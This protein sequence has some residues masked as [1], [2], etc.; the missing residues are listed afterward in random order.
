MYKDPS[1]K[2][3]L[4]MLFPF[5]P[6]L[7]HIL[8]DRSDCTICPRDFSLLGQQIPTPSAQEFLPLWIIV[9]LCVAS[10][11]I[12]PH[13]WFVVNIHMK[14]DPILA[15]SPSLQCQNRQWSLFVCVRES[16]CSD[17]RYLDLKLKQFNKT[18]HCNSMEA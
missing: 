4:H 8:A 9:N 5:V 11:T 16:D 7:K 10:I 17:Y 2:L 12:Q 1:S 14:Q 3:V 15:P 13:S 18:K 6:G